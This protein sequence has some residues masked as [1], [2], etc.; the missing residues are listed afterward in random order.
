MVW[1]II[2]FTL[3]NGQLVE[4]TRLQVEAATCLDFMARYREGVVVTCRAEP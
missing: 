2:F 1:M 3:A 4:A